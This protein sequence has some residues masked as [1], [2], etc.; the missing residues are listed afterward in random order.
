[1]NDQMTNVLNE[2]CSTK[3]TPSFKAAF[4]K[5]LALKAAEAKQIARK[6]SGRRATSMSHALALIWARHENLVNA[7]RAAGT[8]GSR[9]AG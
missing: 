7:K 1:M 8:T 4:N 9:L 3:G 6:F 2:L 5:A